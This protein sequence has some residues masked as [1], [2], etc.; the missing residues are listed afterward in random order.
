MER[1]CPRRSTTTA[2]SSCSRRSAASSPS[3]SSTRRCPGGSPSGAPS[4]RARSSCAAPGSAR[5]TRTA[6]LALLL[7]F[8]LVTA[9]ALR[10]GGGGARGGD[11]PEAVRARRAALLR[12]DAARTRPRPRDADQRAAAAFAAVL[13][14]GF[15]PFVIADPG[16]LWRDTIGYGAGTYRIVGYG[17]SALLLN[18]GIIDDRYGAL[19]VRA[20]RPRSSGCP[21]PRGSSGSCAARGATGRRPRGS[22]SRSSRCSSSPGCSRRRT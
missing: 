11:P 4:R 14:A 17:L 6:I 10:L 20:L 1:S 2:C 22:R 3:S 5:P 12:V 8:A 9:V 16:A 15:L 21:S 18:A 7:A 19:P 13:V